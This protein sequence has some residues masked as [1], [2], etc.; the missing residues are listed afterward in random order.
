MLSWVQ[1]TQ[2]LASDAPIVFQHG[3]VFY[4]L[5]ILPVIMWLS[6][7]QGAR[8]DWEASQHKNQPTFKHSLIDKLD[9]VASVPVKRSWLKGLLS[10]LRLAILVLVLGSL[11]SPVKE[12]PLPPEP[13]TKTVRD[14]VF[15]VET[16]ASMLLTDYELNGQLTSRMNVV[17]SVLDQFVSAL[18]GNRFGFVIYAEKA[19][20]LMPLTSDTTTARLMLKELKPYLAGRTDEAMGAALGLALQQ[21]EENT[22]TT[23]RRVIVLISDGENSPS[24]LPLSE[25][26][27]YAQ[28]LNLPIYTVGVGAGSAQADKRKFKG[29]I[30]RPL[31][32]A[33]LEMLASETLG[34]YFE[35]GSE[36]DLQKVLADID[37]AE[38]VQI[39]VAKPRKKTFYFYPYLL[40]VTLILFSFYFILVQVL[41]KRIQLQGE[42]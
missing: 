33:S 29:L 14:I 23:Q 37:H 11:A 15:V 5:A 17:K 9:L 13:Q 12:L 35:V 21:S 42:G 41:S 20:T 2:L 19:Y 6:Y 39:E 36:Q 10:L 38:G 22:K 31:K 28:G 34:K 32:K 40:L 4:L 18:D 24:K 27:N 25:V 3:W 30:Y 1:F 7:R 16:S 8:S 26:V